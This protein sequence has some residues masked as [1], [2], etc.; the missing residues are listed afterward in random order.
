MG[1]GDRISRIIKA[2]LNDMAG[3]FNYGESTAFVVVGAAVGAGVYQTIGGMGL[4]AAGTA[5][6]IGA[7]HLI[8]T[9]AVAGMA[10]YGTKKGIENRD[11][12]ALSAAAL[13]A[14]GGAG[15][16]ATVGNM[17]LLAAGSG[18]SIGMAP[19]AAAG[20]VVGL[21]AYGLLRLL[22][23]G[24]VINDP[25]KVI[26]SLHQIKLSILENIYSVKVSQNQVQAKFQQAQIQVQQ[27][28]EIAVLAMKKGRE[29]LA[30]EAL[31]RKYNHQQTA[32]QLQN[33]L[34]Q[35]MKL[36]YSLKSDLS[37]IERT[38]AQIK[39]EAGS[40]YGWV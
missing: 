14:A 35:L 39:A 15:V 24:Q 16:S 26:E 22:D 29:D 5:V 13:G 9:G 11:P 27:C 7:P 30:R 37:F 20:A 28:Y 38:I 8:A 19:V 6:G 12:L 1:I 33:Q 17:G 3:N 10:A 40:S 18:F 21:G 2:N 36:T 25:N 34:E 23:K 32:N 31:T 4:A